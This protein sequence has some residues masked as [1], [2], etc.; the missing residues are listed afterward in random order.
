L[1]PVTFFAVFPK[2]PKR[3][4]QG[5]LFEE[6]IMS[7]A[8]LFLFCL[9]LAIPVNAEPKGKLKEREKGL[10]QM[11]RI[12]VLA[13]LGSMD[14]KVR[15]Q[16]IE[17]LIQSDRLA[18]SDVLTL[19]EIAGYGLL[20]SPKGDD[21]A[22]L[23]HGYGCEP[24]ASLQLNAKATDMGWK[25]PVFGSYSWD[26]GFYGGYYSSYRYP[27][28]NAT[29]RNEAYKQAAVARKNEICDSSVIRVSRE[30]SQDAA[31]K[32]LSESKFIAEKIVELHQRKMHYSDRAR[33]IG[34]IKKILESGK[35][36]S[37]DK[38]KFEEA[39][40]DSQEILDAEKSKEAE[41][42]ERLKTK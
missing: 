18:D 38:D 39:I 5:L 4:I 16:A 25:L 14:S 20:P 9:F 30:L 10:T 22:L 40:A 12:A 33:E 36:A 15:D 24:W 26:Y 7:K 6:A 17:R 3:R 34:V 32:V 37:Y 11:R 13:Q 21:Y 28:S 27:F 23:C 42:L 19:L 8:V 35:V 29:E 2:I 31:M 41:L 1:P